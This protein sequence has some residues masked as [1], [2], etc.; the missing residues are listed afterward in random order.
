LEVALSPLKEL[1]KLSLKTSAEYIKIFTSL[2]EAGDLK[3]ENHLF[4]NQ[5]IG[6]VL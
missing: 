2:G 3:D 5:L 6:D 4:H 1:D